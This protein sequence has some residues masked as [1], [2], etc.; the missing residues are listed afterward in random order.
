MH[1]V[2]GPKAILGPGTGL[3]EATMVW[4]E[5]FGGYRSAPF[6]CPSSRHDW[7]CN[8][9]KGVRAVLAHSTASADATSHPGPDCLTEAWQLV[10]EVDCQRHGAR[11]LRRWSETVAMASMPL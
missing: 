9:W 10:K 7:R 1:T 2:Q 6:P 11:V 5:S 4:E 8:V 3:G